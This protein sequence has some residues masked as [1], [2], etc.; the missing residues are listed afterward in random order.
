MSRTRRPAKS[1]TIPV[2]TLI[3]AYSNGIF[4]MADARDDPKILWIDPQWRGI[5]P[6]DVFHVPKRLARTVRRT[7]FVVHVDKAFDAVIAACAR[8]ARGRA[9]TWINDVIERSYIELYRAGH[10]H[11]VEVYD[12]D[13]LIGGLYG[14]SVGAAF[15]GE[16]MFSARRDASKIALVHLVARLKAGRYRLLDTQFVTEHLSQFGAIEIPRGWYQD[17]LRSAIDARA[18]F[19]ELGGAGAA[20]SGGTVLQLITQMS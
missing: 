9:K 16:S 15:F 1:E 3:Q 7:A 12:D 19:Y 6:L 17:L 8:P 5:L 20:V 2:G 18:N 10:A 13:E 4:P 14:V 11:S